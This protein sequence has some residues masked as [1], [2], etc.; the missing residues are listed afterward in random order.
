VLKT[1]LE[2]VLS[3]N[4][5]ECDRSTAGFGSLIQPG[6]RR[7]TGVSRGRYGREALELR[8]DGVLY[9]SRNSQAGDLE[10]LTCLRVLRADEAAIAHLHVHDETGAEGVY[11]I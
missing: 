2:I 7:Q 10:L 3:V 9:I 5:V 6:P 11:I 1:E 8:L 4:L